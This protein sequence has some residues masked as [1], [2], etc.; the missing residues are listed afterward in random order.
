MTYDCTAVTEIPAPECRAL[1]TFF[2]AS[3]GSMWRDH[4]GWLRTPTPCSWYGVTCAAGHVSELVLPAN[5]LVDALP[6][7][8]GDLRELQRLDLHGNELAEPLLATLDDLITLQYLDLSAN[9]FSGAL[10]ANLS[11]LTALRTLNLSHNLLH[12]PIPFRLADL[13]QLTHLDLSAN[14]LTGNL[15]FGDDTPT[16][17]QYLDL[18]NN[19]LDTGM[20][21][22]LDDLRALTYLD[23]SHNALYWDIPAE[24]GSLTALTHL[25]LHANR[26]SGV[27]QPTLG[28]LRALTYLDLSANHLTYNIPPELGGIGSAI[29]TTAAI[30]INLAGNHLLD[31]IP[32]A[33]GGIAGLRSLDLSGNQLSGVVPAA[34]A[35]HPFATLNL[36]YNRLEPTDPRWRDTQTVA[37]TDLRG[38]ADGATVQLTWTPIPYTGAGPYEVWYVT[39]EISYATAPGGPF[40]VAGRTTDNGAASY[41]VT[42]LAPAARYYFRVR[43]FTPA[44]PYW[45]SDGEILYQ[46][47]NLWSDYTPLVSVYLGEATPTPP[48]TGTP[49]PAQHTWLPL[50]WR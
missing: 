20:P 47:N 16:A 27:I 45:G 23:L 30:T 4:T 43:T 8:L 25:D 28:N 29:T 48:P 14:S 26:L 18:S 15:P 19:H 39:Y 32:A 33:L 31:G 46:P 9:Q 41:T 12:G 44:H 13:G 40:T 21:W 38:I 1:V 11:R 36:N 22:V 35:E 2:T 24:Y 42:G 17:L 37:P 3:N 6:A 49:A 5:N 7:A 10:P 34:V 50:V